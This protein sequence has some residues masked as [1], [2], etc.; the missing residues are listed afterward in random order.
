M[1][2]VEMA[3]W[4]QSDEDLRAA[5]LA[6][7]HRRTRERFQALY[8]IASGQFNAT[9]CAAHIGRQD[10]TVL[11][12]VH[13]YNRSG[14]DA[15]TYRKTGG[16]PPLLPSNSSNRSSLSSITANRSS[17]G[18]PATSGHSR[19]SGSTCRRPSACLPV[20]TASAAS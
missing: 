4:G 5:S 3:R 10:E 16:H 14:P 12:W 11:A 13:L 17:T 1:V 8:L 18:C 15:L 20:A 7:A 9:T 19:N 6:A 2:R